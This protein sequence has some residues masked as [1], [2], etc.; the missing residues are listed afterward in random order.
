M[1]EAEGSSGGS[2]RG[3]IGNKD[4]QWR[5]WVNEIRDYL[6]AVKPGMKELL[7]T[8][9]KERDTSVVDSNWAMSKIQNWEP[10][11]F[12]YGEPSQF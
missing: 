3:N 10:N 9:E 2:F 4:E 12:K 7:V 5:E 1:S 11:Q 8:D 6:D